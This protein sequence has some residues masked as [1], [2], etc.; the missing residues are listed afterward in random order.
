MYSMG[1][2]RNS[3]R[4]ALKPG[5][6]KTLPRFRQTR[7]WSSPPQKTKIKRG[8]GKTAATRGLKQKRPPR[9]I[10]LSRSGESSVVSGPVLGYFALSTPVVGP[11][12]PPKYLFQCS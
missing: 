3:R 7:H 9:T 12:W 4:E 1:V 6:L 8:T 2:G 10:E 5:Q 11:V